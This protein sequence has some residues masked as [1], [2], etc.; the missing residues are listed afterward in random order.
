MLL[1]PVPALTHPCSL[2]LELFAWELEHFKAYTD[3]YFAALVSVE[4]CSYCADYRATFEGERR[5][6]VGLLA[7]WRADAEYLGHHLS[8]T[9]TTGFGGLVWKAPEGVYANLPLPF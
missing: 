4:P 6:I 1:E 3:S 2:R 7:L 5:D 9:L 8:P